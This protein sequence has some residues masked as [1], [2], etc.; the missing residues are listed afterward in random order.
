MFETFIHLIFDQGEN[1]WKFV[2]YTLLI[3]SPF[4]G[5]SAYL[6]YR[7]IQEIDQKEKSD[8]RK[9]AKN[10]NRLKVGKKSKKE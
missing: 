6:S 2:Y 7:L 3:L 9:Q 1:P 5:I 8:A 10:L 4:F